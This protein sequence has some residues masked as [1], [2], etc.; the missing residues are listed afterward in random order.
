MTNWRRVL[1]TIEFYAAA[2]EIL[3][4]T[5]IP[6]DKCLLKRRIRIFRNLSK[7]IKINYTLTSR[8][9]IWLILAE[10]KASACLLTYW[11]LLFLILY[12]TNG[13]GRNLLA[14]VMWNW[15][16]WFLPEGPTWMTNWRRVLCTIEFYAAGKNRPWDHKHR[17]WKIDANR[18]VKANR[19]IAWAIKTSRTSLLEI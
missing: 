18:Q 14:N 16:S 1:C 5:R 19:K 12:H 3:L 9:W 8:V 13:L 15:I 6:C 11:I 17:C 4:R 10:W 2:G 7:T